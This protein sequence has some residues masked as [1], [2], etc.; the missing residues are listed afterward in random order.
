MSRLALCCLF[1]VACPVMKPLPDVLPLESGGKSK[2]FYKKVPSEELRHV[3]A[4]LQP[5]TYTTA[6][7]YPRY[8]VWAE[9]HGQE[10]IHPRAFGRR[11]QILIGRENIRQGA[12][13]TS[14]LFLLKA[15]HVTPK[16]PEL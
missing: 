9:N 6:M 3:L 12:P 5:G 11:L 10:P 13:G 8:E 15:E 7:L 14:R 16:G 4:G 2:S 1:D